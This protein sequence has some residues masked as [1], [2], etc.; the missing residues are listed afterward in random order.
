M[1]ILQSVSSGYG[2]YGHRDVKATLCP[3]QKLYNY[4]SNWDEFHAAGPL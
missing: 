3:G 1:Y 2:V 4:I